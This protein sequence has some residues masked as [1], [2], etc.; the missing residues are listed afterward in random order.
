MRGVT[1]IA[2]E[3]EVRDPRPVS[4]RPVLLHFEMR[5]EVLPV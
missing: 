3:V 4:R 1:G 2:D 5:L